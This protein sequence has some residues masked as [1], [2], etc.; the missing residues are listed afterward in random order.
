VVCEET[1]I[2]DTPILRLR[3]LLGRDSLAS[4][5]GMLIHPSGSIHSSF[6][7]FE[8]DAV[9]LDRDLQVVKLV[10]RIPPWR[11]RSARHARSVLE[12]AAG[13]IERRGIQVGDELA[14]DLGRTTPISPEARV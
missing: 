7:R 3:G 13:E 5:H 9:F 11:M 1:E 12:L 10:A 2:A 8:F 6:M 14:V 4:G